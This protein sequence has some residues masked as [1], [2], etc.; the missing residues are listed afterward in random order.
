MVIYDHPRSL[1]SFVLIFRSQNA[2]SCRHLGMQ[3]IFP[4]LFLLSSAL[5]VLM[6]RNILHRSNHIT[7]KF[8]PITLVNWTLQVGNIHLVTSS[9]GYSLYILCPGDPSFLA[10]AYEDIIF[11]PASAMTL[12]ILTIV[13]KIVYVPSPKERDGCQ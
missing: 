1:S 6:K 4:S 9:F 3:L 12:S 13:I 10:I 5:R 11:N 8:S 7:T 2:S